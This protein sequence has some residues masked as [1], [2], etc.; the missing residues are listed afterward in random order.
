MKTY[1]VIVDVEDTRLGAY[2]SAENIAAAFDTA[3]A[4]YKMRHPR[5]HVEAMAAQE[6]ADGSV[7][8]AFV[9]LREPLCL[10]DQ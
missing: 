1:Y 7:D 10:Q 3:T 4:K 2:V 8:P 5:L 9:L 6:V